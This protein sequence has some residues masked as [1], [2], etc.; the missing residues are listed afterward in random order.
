[1]SIIATIVGLVV[2]LVRKIT[3]KKISP[4]CNYIIWLVFVIALVCPVSIPS[5]ISIYNYI[6]VASVKQNEKQH[7]NDIL[8]LETEEEIKDEI[9]TVSDLKE[10]ISVNHEKIY[11]NYLKFIIPDI[12][13]IICLVKLSRIISVYV[14]LDRITGNSQIEDDRIIGIL[15]RCKKKLKIKRNIKIVEQDLIKMPSTMGVIHVKIFLPNE[16][17]DL[18]DKSIENIILH[19]LSH[20][21]RKDNFVNVLIMVAK[22]FY[23]INPIINRL[24]AEMKE[25]IELATDEMAVGDMDE[26]E[27]LQ[28]CKVIVGVAQMY[29]TKEEAVLGLADDVQVL[30][31]R[32]DMVLLKQEFDKNSR[33]IAMIT[34]TIVLLMWLIFYPTSYG[35][36]SVP[37]LYLEL[38]DGRVIE[39]TRLEEGN[40]ADVETVKIGKGESIKLLTE[41]GRCEDYVTYTKVDLTNMESYSEA[42]EIDVDRI[43]YFP[44]KNCIY[45]FTLKYGKNKSIEYGIKIIVE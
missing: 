18:D 21:K 12:W 16:I 14:L 45:K 20:Y 11:K 39:A 36:F 30:E 28:Y 38:E 24:F 43:S 6:D 13:L 23:W 22:C 42:I 29:S 9:N 3:N 5:K 40:E 17:R 41:G 8:D 25:D 44:Y 26:S 35:M 7:S 31:Q 2:L 19:E 37:K 10:E 15:E 4:K 27:K 34:S 33:K 32:I 1:M